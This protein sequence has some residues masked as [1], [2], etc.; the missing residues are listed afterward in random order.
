MSLSSSRGSFHSVHTASF[1]V[2]C[3]CRQLARLRTS[4]TRNN[5]GRK[6][7]NCDN[8]EVRSVVYILDV[9]NMYMWCFDTVGFFFLCFVVH[10]LY[11]CWVDAC[12]MIFSET[13]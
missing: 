3:H 6:F 1:V 5:P 2:L 10:C 13:M 8:F 4:K 9:G 7:W 12:F 11:V